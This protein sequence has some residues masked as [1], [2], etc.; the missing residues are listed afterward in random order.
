MITRP[1]LLVLGLTA[2]VIGGL[3]GGIL[4]FAGMNLIITGQNGGWL[5]L[6]LTGPVCAAI[7][8]VLASRLARKKSA[9]L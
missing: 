3:V 7:G 8:W 9:S 6:L 4:L 2:S 5:L 1:D